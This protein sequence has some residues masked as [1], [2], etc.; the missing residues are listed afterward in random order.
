MEAPL[1]IALTL[2]G[3]LVAVV[4]SVIAARYALRKKA[5]ASSDV[6]REGGAH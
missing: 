4:T 6:V 3:P 5:A 2:I 1:V